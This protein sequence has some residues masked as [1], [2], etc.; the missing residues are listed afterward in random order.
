MPI[1]LSVTGVCLILLSAHVFPPGSSPRLLLDM[2]VACSLIL[3]LLM[4]SLL[5]HK[6]LIDRI[7]IAIDWFVIPL[8]LT[9]LIGGHWL[10]PCLSLSL[11]SLSMEIIWSGLCRGY[12]WSRFLFCVLF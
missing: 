6:N 4:V 12:F 2:A 3:V 5:E 11:W 9:R 10:G 1:A 7:S 8:L